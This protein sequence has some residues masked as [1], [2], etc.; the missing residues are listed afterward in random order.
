MGVFCIYFSCSRIGGLSSFCVI[1]SVL[2][3]SN[4][5]RDARARISGHAMPDI[6]WQWRYLPKPNQCLP[7]EEHAGIISFSIIPHHMVEGPTQVRAG[8]KYLRSFRVCKFPA[9]EQIW[10]GDV[11]DPEPPA[12]SSASTLSIAWTDPCDAEVGSFV[13][14]VRRYARR[15]ANWA[16]LKVESVMS[17]Q[18]VWYRDLSVLA[19]TKIVKAKVRDPTNGV[20][21][22]KAMY[23]IHLLS[24]H[25]SC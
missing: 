11:V 18:I 2:A 25:L 14:T 1:S 3:L 12:G 6:F 19:K 7:M 17:L 5:C 8:C 9:N 24:R 20:F 22:C 16:Q 4:I 10:I 15:R 21:Q 23:S 13:S